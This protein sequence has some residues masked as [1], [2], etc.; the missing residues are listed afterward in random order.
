[1]ALTT[2]GGFVTG[3]ISAVLPEIVTTQFVIRCRVP[4]RVAIATSIF[5]LGVT[6]IAGAAV[7]ALSATPVWYVVAW[8][9]PGVVNYP[10]LLAHSVRSLRT[11]A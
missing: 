7:H 9:I 6:A 8:S 11:G 5:V 4:P 10:V 3:L 1:M 2:T